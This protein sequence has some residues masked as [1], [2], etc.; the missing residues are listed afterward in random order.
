MTNLFVNYYQDPN[1]VRANEIDFCIYA[2]LVS[3]NFDNVYIHVSPSDVK[4]LTQILDMDVIK[5]KPIISITTQRATYKGYLEL[6]RVLCDDE[7]ISVFCNADIMVNAKDFSDYFAKLDDNKNVCLALCRYEWHP[8]QESVFFDRSDSQD[9]WAFCGVP[10]MELL[11][12]DIDFQLGIAG[13]DNRF[14]YELEQGGY[15]VLNP[16]KTITTFH[17]H[18][19]EIRNYLGNNGTPTERI[20]PPYKLIEPTY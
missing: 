17:F 14:A 20:P 3:G 10:K 7:D 4:R 9:T 5:T 12:R 6:M 2:N 15:N 1:I 11:Q 8:Q 16:S 18:D 19:S 13:C